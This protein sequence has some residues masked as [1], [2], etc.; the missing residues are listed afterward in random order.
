VI[1]ERKQKGKENSLDISL[2]SPPTSCISPLQLVVWRF[3]PPEHI[4][5]SNAVQS[6]IV[7]F[8]GR[9]AFQFDSLAPSL[10]VPYFSPLRTAR[11]TSTP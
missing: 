5:A 11:V 3:L 10:D 6:L 4:G 1:E 9:I 8:A 2:A 7:T